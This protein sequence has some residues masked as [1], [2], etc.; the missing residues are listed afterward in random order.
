[1]QPLISAGDYVPIL[2]L[3]ADTAPETKQMALSMG[4][5]DFLNKPFDAVEA[6]LRIHNLLETRFLYLE[7]RAQNERLDQKVRERTRELEEA[8]HEILARLALAAEYRDDQT[9]EHTSGTWQPCWRA[10]SD[11]PTPKSNSSA[12]PR[13]C[14]TSARSGFPTPC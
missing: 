14:T 2:I 13:R 9:G 11:S 12:R 7:L 8:Q 4:A 3:T 6:L 10:S 1:M 5:K